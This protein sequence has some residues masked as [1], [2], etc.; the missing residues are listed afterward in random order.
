MAPNPRGDTA[1]RWVI[2]LGVIDTLAVV[3]R[4]FARKKNG[5]KIAADDWMIMASLVPTYCM[6]VSAI[7]GELHSFR[8]S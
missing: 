5:T 8:R 6:I 4:F 7:L 3:L 1:V 2:V